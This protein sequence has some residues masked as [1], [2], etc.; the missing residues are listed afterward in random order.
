MEEE[1]FQLPRFCQNSPSF[2]SVFGVPD[3]I[4]LSWFLD[5]LP[6]NFSYSQLFIS[7]AKAYSNEYIFIIWLYTLIALSAFK[8]NSFEL[9]KVFIFGTLDSNVWVLFR[10]TYIQFDLSTGELVQKPS[11][12]FFGKNSKVESN[13]RFLK[14]YIRVYHW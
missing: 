11:E 5:F 7:S 12:Q 6:K 14:Y 3:W 10:E 9:N 1:I 4:S 13:S 2:F 8:N